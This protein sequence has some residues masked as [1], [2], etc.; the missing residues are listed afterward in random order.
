MEGLIAFAYPR[1]CCLTHLWNGVDSGV[2]PMSNFAGDDGGGAWLKDE[3]SGARIEL[4][5]AFKI[6]RSSRCHLR[7]GG[8]EAS[9]EHALLNYDPT[10][11]G[12]WLSDLNSTNGTYLNDRK[13]QIST[14]LR[15]GD[16]IRIGTASWSFRRA[17]RPTVSEHS[18]T[19]IDVTVAEMSMQVCWLLFGDVVGSTP[20]ARELSAGEFNRRLKTWT[21]RCEQMVEAHGG[22][23]NEF[24]GDGFLAIWHEQ[25]ATAKH[26]LNA[27][28][29]FRAYRS[30]SDVPFRVV[31][32]RGQ[33]L[34]GGGGRFDGR[35]RITGE[36]VNFVFKAEKV[37]SGL[38]A[39]DLFI[40]EA[41]AVKLGG[42]NALR[43][44]GS[45]SVPGFDKPQAF[46]TI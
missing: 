12:W 2:K 27:L 38:K 24:M 34:F 3:K 22:Y 40:S 46:F 42:A 5:P 9:R 19:G 30:T 7:V 39:N 20:L 17:A 29:D 32:H 28:A 41:A 14:R 45:H 44:L 15:P 33:V 36:D 11:R 43:H 10:G 8:G 1:K 37:A 35:E 21:S 23:V 25:A 16:R 6:G 26:I 18:L 4:T 31:L 13:I